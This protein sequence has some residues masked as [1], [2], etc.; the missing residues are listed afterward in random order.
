[1]GPSGILSVIDAGDALEDQLA[2]GQ[3]FLV[4]SPQA[5]SMTITRHRGID[6]IQLVSRASPYAL[7]REVD[8]LLINTPFLE[9][10][11]AAST[12]PGDRLGLVFMA[13]LAAPTAAG[14]RDDL[15]NEVFDLEMPPVEYLLVARWRRQDGPPGPAAHDAGQPRVGWMTART[16]GEDFGLWHNDGVDLLSA[17]RS[18]WPEADAE[19]LHIRYVA[20]AILP[21]EERA[22][23]AAAQPSQA[24][25][26]TLTLHR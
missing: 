24:M 7:G 17:I 20:A 14:P 6:A 22:S 15:A 18:L 8:S 13:G 21:H 25:L 1:M 3:L 23:G 19:S 10:T 26:G 5:G 16:G 9:W 12:F 4:G 2:A 11:W